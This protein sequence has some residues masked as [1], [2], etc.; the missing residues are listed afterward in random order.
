M[1]LDAMYI[2]FILCKSQK[3]RKNKLL[4]VDFCVQ[5]QLY[6]Y[7]IGCKL[8]NLVFAVFSKYHVTWQSS[9]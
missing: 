4:V 9:S 2:Y 5:T 7:N 6:Q 1:F 8:C 3:L